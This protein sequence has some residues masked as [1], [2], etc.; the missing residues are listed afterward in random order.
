MSDKDNILVWVNSDSSQKSLNHVKFL[1]NKLNLYSTG[2]YTDTKSV[3]YSNTDNL[4]FNNIIVHN[5]NESNSLLQNK[6][7]K[8]APLFMLIPTR[9]NNVEN[10]KKYINILI[11][12]KKLSI[13]FLVIPEDCSPK[14]FEHIISNIEY[15]KKSKDRV[16]WSNYLARKLSAK[17][18]LIIPTE[19]DAY[20]SQNIN[21][22]IYFAEKLF[23]QSNNDYDIHKTPNP[24]EKLTQDTIRLSVERKYGTILLS[25]NNG[26]FLPHIF[27]PFELKIINKCRKK[28]ILFIPPNEDFLIPCH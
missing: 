9:H 27:I 14:N 26:T 16:M 17:I 13:P 25:T 20:I 22:N 18:E 3:H 5:K 2:L 24:S 6:I 19:K 10:L 23:K 11:V 7:K 4:L 28:P 12:I 1:S 21:N 8:I 15:S